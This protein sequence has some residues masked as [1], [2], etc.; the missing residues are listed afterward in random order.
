MAKSKKTKT[1]KAK[2]AME[3]AEVLGLSAADGAEIEFSVG[4][5]E[6]IIEVVG[7]MGLTHAEVAKLTGVGRTKITGIMNRNLHEISIK[8][9]IRV[10]AGI[11]YKVSAKISRVA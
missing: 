4:L 7:E 2:N 9:L 1:L 10:L 5:N 3:L 6:K 8:T 11:G